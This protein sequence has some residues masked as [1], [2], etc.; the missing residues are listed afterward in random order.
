MSEKIKKKQCKITIL[1][2][3]GV[4]KH[5]IVNDLLE[6]N[7]KLTEHSSHIGIDT[8]E[9]NL[10]HTINGKITEFNIEFNIISGQERNKGITKSI[11][12][13]IDCFIIIYDV[14]NEESFKCLK[15]WNENIKKYSNLKDYL[16]C[17][18]GNKVSSNR[19]VSFEKGKKFAEEN[20]CFYYE[21]DDKT[22]FEN[23]L[24]Q[25]IPNLKQKKQEKLKCEIEEDAADSCCCGKKCNI[26]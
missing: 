22:N 24:K 12:E 20:N 4:G 7:D 18:I 25:F 10:L 16:V 15:L 11:Y 1:G 23:I 6:E 21:N 26:Y 17:I 2:E 19:V 13:N 8:K 5:S 3:D 14:C 9:Y